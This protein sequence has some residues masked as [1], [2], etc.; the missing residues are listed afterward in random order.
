MCVGCG[1]EIVRGETR[2]ERS[3]AGCI[4]AVLALLV[5]M[6]IVGMGPL[7][8]PREDEM[9]FLIFKLIAVTIVANAIGRLA[10]RWL[11]RSKLRFFR[12]YEHQ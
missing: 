1:A 9:L 6:T 8:G 4:V 5:T 3:N 10:A 11:R 7:P 2:Q 12:R